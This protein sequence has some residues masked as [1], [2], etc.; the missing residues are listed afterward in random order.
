MW[1]CNFGES[2]PEFM[3]TL[4]K[5]SFRIFFFAIAAT[6]SRAE[7]NCKKKRTRSDF[8]IFLL[9]YKHTYIIYIFIRF[10][11]V[12]IGCTEKLFL[13]IF[14]FALSH[15]NAAFT[16]W[17]FFFLSSLSLF[18]NFCFLISF[19]SRCQPCKLHK[20]FQTVFFFCSLAS[21]L[22]F[23]RFKYF[24]TLFTLHQPF[25]LSDQTHERKM[26]AI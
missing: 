3:V 20:C 19:Y 5:F 24:S 15:F 13:P 7:K 21:S 14:R 10:A 16:T 9:K 4:L 8:Q 1:K 17:N 25:N 12:Y 26:F 6:Q 22:P 11:I 2:L 23:Y 18:L